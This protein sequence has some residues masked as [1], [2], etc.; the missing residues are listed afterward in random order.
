M[1]ENTRRLSAALDGRYRIER[2]LGAGGM[3]TV[4]LAEDLKH[5][6]KVAIKVLK[7]ELAAVLGADRF[8]VEI[9]TTAALQHPHI[10]PLFDS[11]TADG[12][13]FYVMPYIEGETIRE[14]LN[15]ETQFGVEEAVRIARE[16]ADALDYAHRHGV[17]HRDIKPENILLHDGRAMVMD[18]GIALAVSAAAGGR[19][20]ETGL[21]LGTPHY[22][23]PEQATAEKEITPRSDVYSLAS[24]L[25]EM[26]AGEPPHTGGSAQQVI[27]KI[28]VEP[29]PLVTTHR[30]SVPANVADA[31][32]KSLEKL[33]A[34]RFTSASA[35]AAALVDEHFAVAA[36][37]RASVAATR[38]RWGIM[39]G[40]LASVAAF[41]FAAAWWMRGSPAAANPASPIYRF[42]VSEPEGF[43]SVGPAGVILPDGSGF[44]MIVEGPLGRGV[45]VQSFDGSLP[46]FFAAPGASIGNY[47]LPD[48]SG[49]LVYA[50]PAAGASQVQVVPFS[51]APPRVLTDSLR[52]G[53]AVDK[54]GWI[55]GTHLTKGGLTRVD[56]GGKTTEVLTHPDTT[57]GER[58]HSFPVFVDDRIIAFSIL[59]RDDRPVR[60]GFFDLRRRIMQRSVEGTTPQMLPNGYLTFGTNAG[61]IMASRVDPTRLD[62]TST[63]TPV[64]R[65]L[66]ITGTSGLGSVSTNGS[67]L[68]HPKGDSRWSL[69]RSGAD[70][71]DVGITANGEAV[72]ALHFRPDGRALL[73]LEGTRSLWVRSRDGAS[74]QLVVPAREL[75]IAGWSADGARILYVE[76]D[77]RLNSNSSS[78]THGTLAF[79]AADGTGSP[80]PVGR[81]TGNLVREAD[82]GRGGIAYTNMDGTLWWLADGQDKPVA[83]ARVERGT[84]ALAFAMPAVSPDGRFIAYRDSGSTLVV[85]AI[86]PATGSWIVGPGMNPRWS[87][88][89]KFLFFGQP[90][91]PYQT[92]A[93]PVMR[94]AVTMGSAFTNGKPEVAS[95][96][97]ATAVPL[98][99]LGPDNSVYWVTQQR[100]T[101]SLLVVNWAREVDSLV[102]AAKG[103]KP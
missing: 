46:R 29:T 79:L 66:R 27:M 11:G 36:S 93:V 22:M 55:Y 2:E 44:S 58:I 14:K 25:Y 88:D 89:G 70:S 71:G 60:L 59:Y 34:D 30:K 47:V 49:V 15:R 3:A 77:G 82:G 16:V 8:V 38:R 69:R 62:F 84:G 99:D 91:A 83:V 97:P 50:F 85:R 75:R 53:L 40:A 48:N 81:G 54:E 28:I 39:I 92:A 42:A 51:G 96:P 26:L 65:G 5:D 101:P 80:V 1:A 94:V 63:P 78:T 67:M 73:L 6:R 7:P 12:F 17:I 4:Y 87:R 24:V 61:V 90:I 23:S 102:R 76:Y 43:A 100:R 20:T 72:R 57:A 95:V 18:F 68:Y 35:F 98:W 13:L 21:S 33:P 45:V 10:L 86:P 64:L 52:Y 32:A 31:L 37:H 41:G 19:M 103:A 9:K 74:R 56:A